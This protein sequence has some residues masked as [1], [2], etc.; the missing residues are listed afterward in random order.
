[1]SHNPDIYLLYEYMEKLPFTVRM[2]VI[3][4]SPIDA[5]ILKEAA[6]LAIGRL[7]YFS[8]RVGLDEGQNY[9]LDHNEKPLAV[10]PEKD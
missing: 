5:A 7:P 10:L 4:D 6:Q 1:M 8:V 9:T 2:K 3:L